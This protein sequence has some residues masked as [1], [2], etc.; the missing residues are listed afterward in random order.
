MMGSAEPGVQRVR[1][2]GIGVTPPPATF[3]LSLRLTF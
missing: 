2:L 3:M 1:A